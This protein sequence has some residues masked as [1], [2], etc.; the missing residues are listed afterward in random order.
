M[1]NA[2][3][4]RRALRVG[5]GNMNTITTTES[6]K[7][8]SCAKSALIV[9]EGKD[10]CLEHFFGKCY[11]CLDSVEPLV[12]H[13]FLDTAETQRVRGLLNGFANQILF[14]CLRHEPD[15]NLDR[16]RLLELLLRCGELELVLRDR[17]VASEAYRTAAQ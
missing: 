13:R 10:L 17:F 6:C 3:I 5:P 1:R 9:L 7:T 15:S 14:V 8:A 12:R 4:A 16:S 2:L 11:E